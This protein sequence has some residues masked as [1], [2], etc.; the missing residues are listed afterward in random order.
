M[1]ESYER[2]A[3]WREAI[4]LD[5]MNAGIH[6][7][8]SST[9]RT[10]A[11]TEVIRS[12]RK[13]PWYHSADSAAYFAP[14]EIRYMGELLERFAEKYGDEP[15]HFRAVALALAMSIPCAEEGMFVGNQ[16]RV[17]MKRLQKEAQNDLYL[18]AAL[19]LLGVLS[20]DVMVPLLNSLS[21]Y[22]THIDSCNGLCTFK[23]IL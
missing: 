4:N 19:Y 2:L 21:V 1:S 17:F 12:L 9:M 5:L 14:A 18:L 7:V 8:L 22:Y 13:Q 23:C 3:A 10:D 11:R 16:R 6:R 20:F 15:E